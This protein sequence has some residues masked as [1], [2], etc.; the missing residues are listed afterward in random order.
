MYHVYAYK[1]GLDI[2]LFLKQFW[3]LCLLQISKQYWV[4]YSAGFSANKSIK[5]G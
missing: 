2:L 3:A 1:F 5:V 4:Y